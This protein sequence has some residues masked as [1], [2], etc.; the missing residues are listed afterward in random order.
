MNE[1]SLDN[2]LETFLTRLLQWK[3]QLA[4]T[5]IEP[6]ELESAMLELHNSLDLINSY[7]VSDFSKKHKTIIKEIDKNLKK[8]SSL[9]TVLSGDIKAQRP[10][11]VDTN[12]TLYGH[13]GN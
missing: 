4:F 11:K 12:F 2:I 8:V 5:S 6:T 13:F 7:S 10:T 3:K 1:E 9:I